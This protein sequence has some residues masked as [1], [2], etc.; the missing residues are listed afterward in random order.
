MKKILQFLLLC[1]PIILIG[2]KAA[3]AQSHQLV[4]KWQTDTVLKTPESVLYDGLNKVLY[5][6]NIGGPPSGR[7]ERIGGKLGLDGKIIAVE[8]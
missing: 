6:S 2:G 4:K 7:M 1:L 8:W 5:F 3:K